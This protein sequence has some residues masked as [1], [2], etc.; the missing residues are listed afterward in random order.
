MNF[1]NW[2]IKSKTVKMY[3]KNRLNEHIFILF[4]LFNQLFLDKFQDIL[5]KNSLILIE[6]MPILIKIII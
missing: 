5:I 4:G 1:K 6:N 2:S 3:I